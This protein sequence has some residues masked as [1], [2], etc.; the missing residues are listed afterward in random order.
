MTL[1]RA[2]CELLFC[3]SLSL[4]LPRTFCASIVAR[5]A[6]AIDG[7]GKYLFPPESRALS[8]VEFFVNFPRGER[9]YSRR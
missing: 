5:G 6:K 7:I 8:V 1:A 4:S 3:L 2:R 9:S